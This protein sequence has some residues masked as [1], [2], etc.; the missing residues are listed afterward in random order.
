MPAFLLEGIE[1]KDQSAFETWQKILNVLDEKMQFGFLEKAKNV[2]DVRIEGTDFFIFV[3]TKEAL[4][5]FKSEIN[6]QR[7]FI[8]SR[9]FVS[10]QKINVT[11]IDS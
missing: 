9:P 11:M 5:F 3:S 4:E 6:Q 10:L 2:V 7:L 8:V 1:M